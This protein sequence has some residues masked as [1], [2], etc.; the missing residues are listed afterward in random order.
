MPGPEYTRIVNYKKLGYAI[1][2]RRLQLNLTQEQLA[3]LCGLSASYIGCMERGDR[4]MSLDT[5]LSISHALRTTPNVLLSDSIDQEQLTDTLD[6]PLKLREPDYALR[7]TLSNWYLADEPD[8]SM[9]SD[10][11]VTAEDLA[12]LGFLLLGEDFPADTLMQ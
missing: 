11:P 8:E 6:I 4:K 9:L 7:N 10:C 12:K 2:Y 1:A 3:E 5:L